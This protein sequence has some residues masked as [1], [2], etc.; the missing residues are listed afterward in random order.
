MANDLNRHECIGRLGQDP[1][2]RYLQSGEPVC[3]ISVACSTQWKDKQTGEKK[4]RTTWIN[5]VAFGKLADIMSEYLKKGSKVYLSG[6]L[7]TRKWQAQDGQDRYTTEIVA[8][9][10]QML[11]SRNDSQQ[12]NGA[13][14]QNQA[15]QQRQQSE[16]TPQQQ[17]GVY[18]QPPPYQPHQGGYDEFEDQSIPF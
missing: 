1:E 18:V 2:V 4:E 3:N 11:G 7:R 14:S 13:Q 15:P 9:E 10:L 16:Q 17:Q 5:Y 8:S 12:G 6:E